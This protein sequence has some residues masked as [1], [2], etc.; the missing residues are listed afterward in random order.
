MLPRTAKKNHRLSKKKI[1]LCE[2]ARTYLRMGR[3]STLAYANI[4][5]KLQRFQSQVTR[6]RVEYLCLCVFKVVTYFVAF[7]ASWPQETFRLQTKG[8]SSLSFS[9]LSMI[10]SFYTPKHLIGHTRVFV[11]SV[12]RLF[13]YTL[14]YTLNTKIH[15]IHF[16]IL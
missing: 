14:K 4:L 5:A 16:K 6:M 3:G 15:E 8:N 11:G 1:L 12:A 13:R 7:H 2:K 10:A 9:L